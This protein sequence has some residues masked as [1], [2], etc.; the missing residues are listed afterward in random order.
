MT[1]R[2][3]TAPS[4]VGDSQHLPALDGLRGLAILG[5]LLFHTDHLAGGFLGVDLFFA[6]SGYLITGLLL[7]EAGSTGTVSLV[8]FWGRRVRRLLP[9]LAVMLAVA[10]VVVRLGASP[11]TVRATFA[12]GP[13]VQLNLVNWH[14]LAESASYWDR[15]GDDR[16]FGHLWSVAVE[17]QFYLVWPVV[18][19]FAVRVGASVDRWVA[20]VAATGS[21]VSLALMVVLVDPAD[22]TRVY[23]GTDTRAFSLLLGAA[24]ATAPVRTVVARVARRSGA[25]ASMIALTLGMGVAWVL[26]DGTTSSWLFHGGLFVHS[27][28]AAL[29]IG[30]CVHAPGA[31]M[32]RAFSWRPLRGLGLVSYSLYLW[33]WP[34]IV[35]FSPQRTGLDGW[36]RTAAVFVVSIGAAVL[37]KLLVEDPIRFRARWARGRRGGL[38]VVA[39]MVALAVLWAAMPAPAPPTIDVTELR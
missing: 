8:A 14:L 30:L 37:S 12:D 31:A 15:F 39:A 13:W 4:L 20:I 3:G 1:P 10:A 32:A 28:A 25:G 7:R 38:A 29:L 33:H 24:V 2:P 36:G 18:L 27:V 5:V 11:P 22:P 26:V 16:V 34:V 23:T 17:E 35:L 9:A 21:V 19:L 6:L